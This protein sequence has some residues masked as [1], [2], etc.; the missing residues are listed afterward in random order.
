MAFEAAEVEI[1]VYPDR[2]GLCRQR[3]I[4]RAIDPLA[5]AWA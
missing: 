1:A 5:T 4:V 2:F 3:D